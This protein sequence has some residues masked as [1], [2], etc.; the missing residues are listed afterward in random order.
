MK[1]YFVKASAVFCVMF[2]ASCLSENTEN[3]RQSDELFGKVK[4]F[5]EM[6]YEA[7]ER[8]GEIEK[9]KRKRDSSIS[10]DKYK[11][12][13]K[14]GMVI[15]DNRYYSNGDLRLSR[16]YKYDTKGNLI[17]ENYAHLEDDVIL[18]ET[19]EYDKKGNKIEY[20]LYSINNSKSI[21]E[22][23]IK[24]KYDVYENLIE[25]NEYKSD[26]SLEA[27]QIYK[28]DTKGNEIEY[29]FFD[30]TVSLKSRGTY[31]YDAKGNVVEENHYDSTGILDSK[32]NYQYDERGNEIMARSYNSEL[33]LK[34]KKTNKYDE[35]GNLIETIENS[36]ESDGSLSYIRR[37]QYVEDG[38]LIET[39]KSYSEGYLVIESKR[40]CDA[41][42]RQ[43]EF[44]LK[45]YDLL[46]ILVREA[47]DW[48]SY[49]EKGN[50]LEHKKEEI[51]HIDR[52]FI[53]EKDDTGKPIVRTEKKY[54]SEGKNYYSKRSY[55][56]SYDK[57]GNWTRRI[58]FKDDKPSFIEERE[59]EYFF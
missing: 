53:V 22:E 54:L 26:G 44:H 42:G 24:Y 19:F 25:V 8:F 11:K 41:Y 17:E 37:K 7:N 16:T 52:T 47:T 40:I 27:R 29:N 36:Y 4:S 59:Y 12:Y 6:S 51:W 21:L 13:N 43:I 20:N 48:S 46:G 1:T 28:H 55:Q 31:E 30:A 49:D 35:K 3:D 56:Y 23:K 9:G 2:F 33:Q 10:F 18:R 50:L 38:N 32:Y 57:Y 34:K 45:D 5:T 15:E 14:K 58:E 39:D